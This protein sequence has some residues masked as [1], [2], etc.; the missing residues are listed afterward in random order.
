MRSSGA[1]SIE[2]REYP[3]L[4]QRI[5]M[6]EK[7]VGRLQAMDRNTEMSTI[8]QHYARFVRE[9]TIPDTVFEEMR[10]HTLDTIGVCLV[11]NSLAY[12]RLLAELTIADGGAPEATL[13]GLAERVPARSAAFFNGCLGHGRRGWF[14]T[15]L[16]AAE[17]PAA[18]RRGMASRGCPFVYG[19][20]L[21]RGSGFWA[22]WPA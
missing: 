15:H 20:S 22:K 16:V 1:T 21:T 2:Y 12:A 19:E 8:A 14:C 3:R 10:W 13:L 18:A 7:H 4:R 17:T 11:A 9:A 5:A 6:T